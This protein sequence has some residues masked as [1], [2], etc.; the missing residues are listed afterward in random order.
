MSLDVTFS[1]STINEEGLEF[2]N[3][4]NVLNEYPNIEWMIDSD[5]TMIDDDEGIHV[6]GHIQFWHNK[7][8][9]L[10]NFNI[11]SGINNDYPSEAI[12]LYEYLFEKGWNL[13]IHQDFREENENYWSFF[14]NI[15]LE[16]EE[17]EYNYKKRSPTAN[18]ARENSYYNEYDYN[19][20][21]E[22]EKNN[23]W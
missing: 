17:K 23:I 1:N 3:I 2:E 9:I 20:R 13:F 16:E 15:I 6:N 22:K 10:N 4:K 12:V 18:V 11:I 7:E 14:D 8:A 5:F 19:K 21:K